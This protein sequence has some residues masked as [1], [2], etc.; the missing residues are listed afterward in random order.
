[1]TPEF[2]KARDMF[3]DDYDLES[4]RTGPRGLIDVG[5]NWAYDWCQQ[6]HHKKYDE[7]IAEYSRL[8]ASRS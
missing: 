5:A 3:G 1:M 6:R 2:E 8:K 4:H 7:L